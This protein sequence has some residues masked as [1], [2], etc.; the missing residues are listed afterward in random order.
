MKR[1]VEDE[2]KEREHTRAK[3]VQQAL[4]DLQHEEQFR[5]ERQQWRE[6]EPDCRL[7][8]LR[9]DLGFAEG[10]YSMGFINRFSI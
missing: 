3:Q 10:I 1:R 4:E 7:D 8:D 6:A 5:R 9:K 2:L